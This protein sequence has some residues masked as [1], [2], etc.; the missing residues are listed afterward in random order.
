M[1]FYRAVVLWV[2]PATTFADITAGIRD[3]APVGLVMQV[4]LASKK[5]NLD[6]IAAVVLFH[7]T[8]A[9]ARLIKAARGGTFKVNGSSPYS[10]LCTTGYKFQTHGKFNL[11]LSR[12][13]RI[14]GSPEFFRNNSRESLESMLRSD[15]EAMEAAGEYELQSEPVQVQT[16]QDQ[17]GNAVVTSK[18]APELKEALIRLGHS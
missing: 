8:D 1:G 2:D 6:K 5:D 15:H 3:T 17:Q 18:S 14:C 12:V 11:F 10:A 9:A 7:S 13:M 4:Q 16:T